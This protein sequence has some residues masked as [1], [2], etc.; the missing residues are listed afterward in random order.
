ML[1]CLAVWS[2]VFLL[3]DSPA[4][5]C[6]LVQIAGPEVWCL[7]AATAVVCAS[8]CSQ[9]FVV[10]RLVL[11]SYCFGLF[12]FSF[13]SLLALF[14]DLFFLLFGAANMNWL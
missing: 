6:F 14:L 8:F 3:C 13:V 4:S 12:C 7:A 10:A 1:I 5:F 11:V 9:V 2:A